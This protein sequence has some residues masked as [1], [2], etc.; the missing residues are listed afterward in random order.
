MMS[1]QFDVLRMNTS[2]KQEEEVCG[3]VPVPHE[4]IVD[5]TPHIQW[6]QV[7]IGPHG[8]RHVDKLTQDHKCDICLNME[9]C[10]S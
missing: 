10:M 2:L 7:Q 3:L 1:K 9:L 4:H 5:K 8:R 6:W